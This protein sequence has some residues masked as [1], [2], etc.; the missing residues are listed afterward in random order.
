MISITAI[1][2]A[3]VTMLLCVFP[4]ATHAIASRISYSKPFT[5]NGRESVYGSF[6]SMHTVTRC[7]FLNSGISMRPLLPYT[8]PIVGICAPMAQVRL[9]TAFPF[10]RMTA[11]IASVPTPFITRLL[12]T[13]S[14]S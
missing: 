5:S 12:C 6:P 8:A 7:G 1:V 11:S 4:A 9:A 14:N 2:C 10:R 3:G 13:L